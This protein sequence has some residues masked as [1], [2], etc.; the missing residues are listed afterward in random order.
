MNDS[1][2]HSPRHD[3]LTIAIMAV[4]HYAETHPRPPHVNQVQAAEMLDVSPQTLNKLVKNGTFKLNK[5]G[6]I[7]ITQI[8]EAISTRKR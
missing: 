6:L 8:D 3:A 5:L 1:A 7:P 2:A 4:Q